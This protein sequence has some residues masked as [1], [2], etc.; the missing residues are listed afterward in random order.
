MLK[1]HRA[2]FA[3]VKNPCSMWR[4]RQSPC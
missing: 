2:K 4:F 3:P 1:F